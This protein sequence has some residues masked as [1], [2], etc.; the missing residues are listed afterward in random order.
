MVI[1]TAAIILPITIIII[2]KDA[3]TPMD[4]VVVVSTLPN[5]AGVMVHVHMTHLPA[6]IKKRAAKRKQRLP[7]KWVA[8]LLNVATEKVDG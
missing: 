7:T 8:Q 4:V 3:T 6:E 2:R 1:T 5:T